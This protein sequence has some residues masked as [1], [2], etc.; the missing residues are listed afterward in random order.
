MNRQYIADNQIIEK[1]LMGK[2]SQ[3]ERDEFEQ[4]YLSDQQTLDDLEL[5]RRLYNGFVALSKKSSN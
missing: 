4:F 2:L 5:A 3:H 1:Y